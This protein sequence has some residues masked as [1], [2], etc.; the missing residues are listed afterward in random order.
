MRIGTFEQYFNPDVFTSN[1]VEDTEERR[2][3]VM[4]VH[5]RIC[6]LFCE[7]DRAKP[8]DIDVLHSISDRLTEAEFELQKAWGFELDK[9]FHSYW[10]RLP[11]CTCPTLDNQDLPY[12]IIDNNCPY[13]SK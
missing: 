8:T 1:K 12:T 13:H 4:M 2:L 5:R 7:A 10:S 9:S 6:E 11:H 3:Q